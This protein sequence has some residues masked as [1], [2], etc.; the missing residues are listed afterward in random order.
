[1]Q[2]QVSRLRS[3]IGRDAVA[4]D[5]VGYRLQASPDDVDA[6]RFEH[7]ARLG[8][9][10][11]RN[12]T[13]EEARSTLHDAL[14]LWRGRA[15]EGFEGE[16]WAIPEAERLES[17]RLD[18]IEDRVEADLNAGLHREVVDEVRQLANEHPF[19]ERLWSQLMLALY[20]SG[21]QSDALLVYQDLRETLAEEKGLDPGPE[22]QRLEA[23][24]LSQ[25]PS[26]EP[27]G[28]VAAAMR[29]APP[30]NM[31][32]LL[33]RFI[34]R[35]AWLV[36][37]RRTIRER[38]LV[39]LLGPG[40][41]GKTRMAME[42][43]LSSAGEFSEGSWLV[44]LSTIS[45][46]DDVSTAVTAVLEAK[47]PSDARDSDD[48]TRRAI[49]SLRDRH[50][51]L[52]LDNCEHVQESAAR[53]I[54]AALAECARL[55]VLATSR[56]PL[57]IRGETRRVVPPLD[58]PS[59]DVDD[60]REILSSEAV[61]LFEDRASQV[62]S[63]FALTEDNAGDIVDLCRRLDGSPLAI[64]L[65]AAWVGTL[66]VRGI[67]DALDERFRLLVQRSGAPWDRHRSLRATLDWSWE[68]LA[69]DE[70]DL[71]ARLSVFVGGCS[72]TAALGIGERSGLDRVATLDVLQRLVDRSFLVADAAGPE[73]PRY[74]M[75]ETLQAYGREHLREGGRLE[76]AVAD[77]R[78]FFVALAERAEPGIR[79]A[80]HAGW[81]RR[82][83]VEYPNLRSAL[84]SA[85]SGG[86]ADAALRIAA[87]LWHFWAITNRYG[88][89]CRWLEEA[90]AVGGDPLAEQRSLALSALCYLAWERRDPE[91]AVRAG[92]DAIRAA[93]E[94]GSA[95]ALARAKQ[96][97][98]L[99]TADIGDADR[100]AQLLAEARPAVEE[101]GDLWFQCG[102]DLIASSFAVRSG[103]LR[104]VSAASRRVLDRTTRAGYEPFACWAHLLLGSVADRS[105]LVP[106]ARSSFEAALELARS[107]A[108][109]HYV[110]F[111]TSM[112]G[113]VAIRAGDVGT[114]RV[115]YAEALEMAEEARARW[116]AAV[117]R[118][119]LADLLDAEER[120]EAACELRQ[121][122]VTWASSL[123]HL[124]ARESFFLTIAGDPSAI[125]SVSLGARALATDVDA[126]LAHVLRGIEAAAAE[127]DRATIASALERCAAASFAHL[128]AE[129][130][131]ALIGAADAIRTTSVFPP[132]PLDTRSIQ[133]VVDE[134]RAVLPH[135]AV[136]DA[137]RRGRG[138][139]PDAAVEL[140]RSRLA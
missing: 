41:I 56:E 47:R 68:H 45:D 28:T 110:S 62:R 105:G 34:G 46:P 104:A 126:G 109:P 86:D 32:P 101:R 39:T 80:D 108:L 92:D 91:S 81:Q 75:L 113:R 116:F 52:I 112:L 95:W 66:S 51:L 10:Q 26:I 20:R 128:G 37:L 123:P 23:A 96:A 14:A 49:A 1:L 13:V 102:L 31:A 134:A 8:K 76:D 25:E 38:R 70:Q 27:G 43:G 12:D 65:A 17:L 58:L 3:S 121:Q 133:R 19:R 40:G 54:E 78:R 29:S 79:G 127:H 18:A 5:E 89:G 21:R 136:E 2:H 74:V 107:I 11:I 50:L 82:L 72:L 93:D 7:L 24:I 97:L 84:D 129:D 57:G 16:D 99:V 73:E 119:G 4:R 124:P 103:D 35:H 98:A 132:T 63:D 36:D 137:L 100:A 139:S 131:C 30:G 60:V 140:L 125:A 87:S 59:E 106:E 111:A 44:D 33:T 83:T 138:L 77:H 88:E 64:E 9:Q 120:P 118:V 115:R 15:L 117:A 122:V 114:A 61:R 48:P 71:F 130:A 94:A 6:V 90:L 135:G 69:P 22:A 42:A 55:H 67:V 85:I 53:F